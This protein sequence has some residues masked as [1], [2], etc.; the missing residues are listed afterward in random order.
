VKILAISLLVCCLG[1]PALGDASGRITFVALPPVDESGTT[2][3]AH[4]QQTIA[5][6]LR[7]RLAQVKTVRAIPQS[8]ISFALRET[9]LD[10]RNA[11]NTY[12]ARNIGE[13]A[14]AQW[15]IWGSYL[16]QEKEWKLAFHSVNVATGKESGE[17]TVT[18]TNLVETTSIIAEKV[19]HEM[20]L[21]SAPDLRS[22]FPLPNSEAALELWSQGYAGIYGPRPVADSE[23][24]LRQSLALDPDFAP[25][26]VY[27]ATSLQVQGRLEEAREA[28]KKAVKSHPDFAGAHV[29]LAQQYAL[30]GLFHIATD[31]CLAAIRLDAD[32][33]KGYVKLSQV[34][35]AQ[36][37]WADAQRILRQ[38][39]DL[40]PRDAEARANLGIAD[41]YLGEREKAVRELDLAEKYNVEG[42]EGLEADQALATG[43]LLLDDLLKA[44]EYYEVLLASAKELGLPAGTVQS[45]EF[46]LKELKKRLVPQLVPGHPPVLITTEA[47]EDAL[48]RTL[49]T[50][51]HAL[52]EN[53]LASAPGMKKWADELVSGETDEQERA[54]RLFEGLLARRIDPSGQSGM[55]TA[56][57]AFEAWSDPKAIFGYQDYIFLYVALARETGLRAWYVLVEEDYR[58]T[59]DSRHCAGVAVGEQVLLIDPGYQWFGVPHKKY[60]FLND[61]QITGSYMLQ[62]SLD[63]QKPGKPE[64]KDLAMALV[65]AKLAGDEPTVRFSVAIALAT[66]GNLQEARDQL[67]QG[68]KVDPASWWALYSKTYVEACEQKREVTALDW[69]RI[70]RLHPEYADGRF[71]LAGALYHERRYREAR[72]EYQNYLEQQPSPQ[73]GKEARKA[74]AELDQ[75]LAHIPD[76]AWQ[77]AS[78]AV[79]TATNQAPIR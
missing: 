8:S 31:E 35:L 34:Y 70:Q 48:N 45:G 66:A 62:E 23:S 60:R 77:A 75:I 76:E 51:E 15:V 38:A 79:S 20:G 25:C 4:W 37:Q 40:A 58:G 36:G 17:L 29:I 12:Q 14:E 7:A 67:D 2:N 49:T 69:A 41:F 47:F 18:G 26:L 72:D 42:R 57:Q 56:R 52:V 19:I 59:N 74:C 9:K 28:A 6:I 39:L 33:P 46:L 63:Q 32:D 44:A 22:T 68:L 71:Y 1:F 10:F 5:V 54:R 61:L 3:T 65:A 11:L 21:Q 53:P 50:R 24:L 55:R 30:E 64:I 27:L 16:H 78:N 43:F 73:L 13:V